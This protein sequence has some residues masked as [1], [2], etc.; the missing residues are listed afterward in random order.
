M[1]FHAGTSLSSL[2]HL[3]F[4]TCR[5]YG[6]VMSY[7]LLSNL[8]PQLGALHPLLLFVVSLANNGSGE[9]NPWTALP[10]LCAHQKGEKKRTRAGPE[11]VYSFEG[12]RRRDILSCHLALACI[13]GLCH[14]TQ[15]I[16]GVKLN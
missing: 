1:F 6:Q 9:S 5:E 4:L 11:P 3:L 10:S 12:W 2:A 13:A 14:Q 15:V 16:P 7:P 8:Q